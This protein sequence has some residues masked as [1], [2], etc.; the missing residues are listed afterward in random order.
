M[1]CCGARL[2]LTLR[3]LAWACSAACA[4]ARVAASRP[5]LMRWSRRCCLAHCSSLA[6][7]SLACRWKAACACRH[8]AESLAAADGRTK[9]R[10]TG[11]RA[12]APPRA[13]CL[14]RKPLSRSAAGANARL[15]MTQAT[16]HVT[17]CWYRMLCPAM[18]QMRVCDA[19]LGCE[20][21]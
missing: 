11:L 8:D 1:P 10:C 4:A 19:L 17:P 2:P 7:A 6:R 12:C 16:S 9:D 20:S 21:K 3:A 18:V 13:L 15:L 5:E 14:P